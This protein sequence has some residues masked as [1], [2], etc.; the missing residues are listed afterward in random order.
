MFLEK[1]YNDFVAHTKL[2]DS[3]YKSIFVNMSEILE[4]IG[5]LS[6]I[7]VQCTDT[8]RDDTYDFSKIRQVPVHVIE[9]MQNVFSENYTLPATAVVSVM[10]SYRDILYTIT[11]TAEGVSIPPELDFIKKYKLLNM[12][13]V[14]SPVVDVFGSFDSEFELFNSF[15]TEMSQGFQPLQKRFEALEGSQRIIENGLSESTLATTQLTV[16]TLQKQLKDSVQKLDNI[17]VAR[18][19]LT[20]KRNAI[21]AGVN[22]RESLMSELDR[23]GIE[24]TTL[25]EGRDEFLKK[26]DDVSKILHGI[27]AELANLE[28]AGCGGGKFTHN[29]DVT[30]ADNTSY[31]IEKRVFCE[32]EIG[33]LDKALI[34]YNDFINKTTLRLSELQQQLSQIEGHTVADITVM[35]NELARLNTEQENTFNILTGLE[36][37]LKHQQ[38]KLGN[39]GVG[40]SAGQNQSYV[41]LSVQ[42]VES[43]M[44]TDHLAT[45][46]QPTA[47]TV[48]RNYFRELFAY[49]T[50]RISQELLQQVPDLDV[51]IAQAAASKLVLMRVF[52]LYFNQMFSF[53]EFTDNRLLKLIIMV[54]DR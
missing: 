53:V 29:V 21:Y 10:V 18:D 38:T 12:F 23:V 46:P 39:D 1:L 31:L 25:I 37:E 45:A 44:I 15:R 19:E 27:N 49:H 36:V 28:A 42:D 41:D 20:A 33:S 4:N 52:G 30:G 13:L 34:D 32:K 24:H 8:G 3:V 35:D 54:K 5:K 2:S 47:V 43:N 14:T 11:H 50:T 17:R 16:E 40:L 9:L 7:S 26:H 48:V 22:S 6:W 51:Y